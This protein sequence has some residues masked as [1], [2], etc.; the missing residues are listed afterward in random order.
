MEG[1]VMKATYTLRLP[2]ELR[3]KIIKEAKT[4][5]MSRMKTCYFVL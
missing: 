1:K 4:N 3:E 2:E 5:K